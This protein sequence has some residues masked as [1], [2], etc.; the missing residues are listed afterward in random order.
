MNFWGFFVSEAWQEL[1][2][3]GTSLMPP[4]GS[5]ILISRSQFMYS[6]DLSRESICLC[7][8]GKCLTLSNRREQCEHRVS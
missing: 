4:G 6:G 5:L 7:M 2:E 3:P 1:V 8:Y